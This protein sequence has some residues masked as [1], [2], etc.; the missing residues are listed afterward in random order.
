[1]MCADFLDI[2]SELDLFEA[3]GINMLH[4]DVMDGHFVPNFSLSFDFCKA[5]AAYSS[6]P[7]DIHLMIERVDEHL[8]LFCAIPGSVVTFHPETS[9][10][11]VRTIQK[12]RALGCRPGIAID[13]AIPVESLRY[14]LPLVEQVCVMTVNPGY[15]GQELLPFCIE[16]IRVLRESLDELEIPAE[17]EVDGNVSWENI[18]RMVEAGSDILV[19][20]TSSV[21]SAGWQRVEALSRMREMLKEL[22]GVRHH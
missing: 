10:H 3:Y 13:P 4:I 17:I 2:R 11:P 7:L 18:P 14:L 12:I 15:A 8:D 5:I 16:K 20:G 1:M 6:I 19:A 22:G 21:F 9:R